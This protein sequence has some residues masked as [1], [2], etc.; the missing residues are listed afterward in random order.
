MKLGIKLK[1]SKSSNPDL[2]GLIRFLKKASK[3]SNT[4]IWRSVAAVLSK[5][6]SN[7]VTINLSRIN[8]HTEKN[9]TVVIGGKVLGSGNLSHPV[10]VAAFEFS[11]TARTKI[12][13]AKGKCLT[14]QELVKRNPS[15][16]NV[17]VLG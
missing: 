16:T 3:E 4:K 7:R 2:L 10:T 5:T 12:R 8:R 14:L 9:Q 1:K 13:K 15:G 11:T 6:R 17:K